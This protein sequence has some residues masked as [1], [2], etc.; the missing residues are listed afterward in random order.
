MKQSDPSQIYF[1][2]KSQVESIIGD[3]FYQ[4]TE[5]DQADKARSKLVESARTSPDGPAVVFLGLDDRNTSTQNKP[6]NFDHSTPEGTAYFAVDA[7]KGWEIDGGEWGDA[8][9]SSMA[10]DAW[11]AN[12]FAQ[13]RALIDWNVRNRVRTIGP[14]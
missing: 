10:M 13:G 4:P 2:D 6:T 14:R 12:L 8:R 1:V 5:A 11:S 3:G 7:P 9:T